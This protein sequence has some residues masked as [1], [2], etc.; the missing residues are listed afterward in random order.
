[1]AVV[2]ALASGLSWGSGDFIAGRLSRRER[3]LV[4]LA[5]TQ[6]IGLVAAAVLLPVVG[7]PWPGI[8]EMWPALIAGAVGPLALGCFYRALAIGTM[9]V[10]AP[11]S[12]TAVAVPV[13]AGLA[14]GDRP[15]AAAI[16]GIVLAAIGIVLASREADHEGA[17]PVR[18]SRTSILLALGA[19]L[20]F[21]IF[22]TAL[23]AASDASVPWALVL[24]RGVSVTMCICALAT[25]KGRRHP[26]SG[27]VPAVLAVGVLDV[28]ANGL[29]AV[30]STK[31]LL[32]VVSVLGSLYPVTTVI[33]AWALLHERLARVQQVGVALAFAGVA[34]ISV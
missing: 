19:A 21:G 30:A 1:M 13:I 22:F 20:G 28:G 26:Q 25:L 12:A 24:A 3:V 33:L 10:V 4:V 15:G 18:A 31:G 8:A 14:T 2:L 7:D 29:Y 32:S 17:P 6:L 5:W 23:P 34:L 27:D 11:I 9:S 16:V